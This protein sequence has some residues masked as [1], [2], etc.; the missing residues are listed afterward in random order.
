MSTK[1]WQLSEAD[2]DNR[3][4]KDQYMQAANRYWE[5]RW[6]DE[7][8]ENERLQADI[9]QAAVR[10]EQSQIEAERLRI[11]V[12]NQGATIVRLEHDIARLHKALADQFIAFKTELERLKLLT[13]EK[14]L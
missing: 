13:A 8:T 5:G 10:A 4:A 9:L 14:E 3:L 6:R 7:K 2:R 12:N 1:D 11:T